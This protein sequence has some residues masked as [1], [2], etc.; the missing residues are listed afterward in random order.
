MDVQHGTIVLD[1][2]PVHRGAVCGDHEVKFLT[3]YSPFLNPIENAF[4]VFKLKVREVLR[5]ERTVQ[6]LQAVQHGVTLAEHRLRVL[7]DISVVIL[8]DQDTISGQKVQNM[9]AN[10]MQCMHR[11]STMVDIHVV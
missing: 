6:R 8:E 7:Q 11:C 3:A 2:A 9:C 5:E 4:A 1:N 10:V